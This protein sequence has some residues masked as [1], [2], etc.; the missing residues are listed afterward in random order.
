VVVEKGRSFEPAEIRHVAQKEFMNHTEKGCS[1]WEGGI[2]R[3]KI[4]AIYKSLR[5]PSSMP[6]QKAVHRKKVLGARKS[7]K[8]RKNRKRTNAH[9]TNPTM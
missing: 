9:L 2:K 5:E 3:A 8:E 6:Y 7:L 1:R 4:R